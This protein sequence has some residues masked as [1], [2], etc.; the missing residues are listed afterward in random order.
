M[1]DLLI[2]HLKTK[3]TEH[4]DLSLLVNQWGFDQKIIPKA[5]QSI[6]SLFPHF[7]RH[8][9][10]HSKQILI[11]IERILGKE[12]IANLTATDTWLI[13]ESAYWHDIGMVV[14]QNDLKE[15]FSDPDF[16]HY[17]D[18]IVTDKNHHLN[19]FCSNFNNENLIDSFQ[20]MGSPIEATDNFRQL[21]AEWFRRK[22]ANRAEQTVN[23]PWESA[24]I[25]SPRT[26]LIPKRLF[27]I[28]GQICALHGANFKEIVGENGLPY[29]EAGLGQEDCHPRF[30][31]CMLRIGDLLDLD[32]NRFC[33]VMKK[34]AGDSRPSLSKAHE[35]KHAAIRH[36]RIDKDRI[37]VTAECNSV[38][39]YLESYKWFEWLKQET[40]A[41]MSLWQEIAP[42]RS[43][44]LLPTLGNI[45]VKLSGQQQVLS[46]GERPQFKLDSEQAIKLLQGSNLYASKFACIRELLQNAVDATL[47]SVWL[48]NK[49][50][51]SCEKWKNPSDPGVKNAID[52]E[53]IEISL[54]EMG[55]CPKENENSLWELTIKDNGTGFSIK[56]FSYLLSISSSSKNKTKKDIVD[57]MPEW[58][59]PSGAFGIG[60][61]SSFILADK[62]SITTKS[63]FTNE[64]SH[65]ELYNPLGEKEGLALL[66]SLPNDISTQHGSEVKVLFSLKKIA[67]SWSISLHREPS[68]KSMILD[69]HDP[70][71][72]ESFPFESARIADSIVDFA[73]H[74]PIRVNGHYKLK[75][76]EPISLNTKDE[77]KKGFFIDLED[78]QV[79]LL[80]YPTSHLSRVN[81]LYRGQE[82]DSGNIRFLFADVTI[83]LL[84]GKAGAWLSINRDEINKEASAKLI[85]VIENS[86]FHISEKLVGDLK[87]NQESSDVKEEFKIHFSLF[88]NAMA[89]MDSSNNPWEK[90][91]DDFNRFDKFWLKYKVADKALDE[92]LNGEPLRIGE[93]NLNGEK[94]SICNIYLG[95][96]PDYDDLI[97]CLVFKEWQER[98]GVNTIE[99]IESDDFKNQKT[100]LVYLCSKQKPL[101]PYNSNAL[102]SALMKAKSKSNA[103]SR[104]LI[105]P[106]RGFESLVLDKSTRLN[107]HYLFDTG[108]GDYE[109]MLLPHLF[110]SPKSGYSTEGIIFVSEEKLDKLCEWIKPKLK[111]MLT[112]AE[113]KEKY[114]ELIKYIDALMA[115]SPYKDKWF[116]LLAK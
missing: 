85:Q 106:P 13:L 35:D 75:D 91:S 42:S 38:D 46:E 2:E 4:S 102:L 20:F 1:A 72:D 28:L 107:A 73:K 89:L 48:R 17:I 47:I 5:L 8:D 60:F 59:K 114:D 84:S 45:H 67:T 19:E 15:A 22:H 94:V 88:L 66:K 61:Q 12:N 80:F 34:I 10:S 109:Y 53:A 29:K 82:F 99:V 3:G 33:P 78:E 112:E 93:K 57:S 108:V 25:S 9:E 51:I 77:E 54:K 39:S 40:Q 23:T 32:D 62:V 37:E 70:N 6:G 24:G 50:K 98:Y 18:S 76:Q 31:A 21:M 68:V 95:N 92:H 111:N 41:Q 26:E 64:C 69:N 100:D 81:T 44:G 11:N 58:M 105:P 43:F 74:S 30:V 79:E 52:N 90:L 103:N 97:K 55:E 56:D 110:T 104:F 71:L 14:P 16:R 65:A 115:E 7:S 36:L 87:A 83:N 86:L 101:Q 49:N 96:H 116:K 113:I 27:R 63:L